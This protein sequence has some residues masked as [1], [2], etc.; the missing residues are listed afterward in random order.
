[1]P[2]FRARLSAHCPE[3][4]ALERADLARYAGE[5]GL[6]AARFAACVDERRYRAKIDA[7]LA[8]ARSLGADGTPTFVV[9]GVVLAG[10]RSPEDFYRV[11]D[12]ELARA[13]SR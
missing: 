4:P 10:T 7:D 13:P 9:N 1:M 11:I 5:L 3:S 12:A 8:A 2:I 6:D